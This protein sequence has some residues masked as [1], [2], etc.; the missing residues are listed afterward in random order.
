MNTH[1][2][3]PF[4]SNSR[5]TSKF[6]FPSM[7]GHN[8][9]GVKLNTPH[10]KAMLIGIRLKGS[11]FPSKSP[12]SFELIHRSRRYNVTAGSQKSAPHKHS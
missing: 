11:S 5:S 8:P 4:S 10:M 3:F 2:F 6:S 7:A 9:N 12:G 1:P